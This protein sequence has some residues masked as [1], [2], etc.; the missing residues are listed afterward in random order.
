MAENM[1]CH[2]CDNSTEWICAQCGEPV[3]EDCCAV[4]SYMNLIEE[5]RCKECEDGI[6][7]NRADEWFREHRKEEATNAVKAARAKTRKEND[8]KPENVQKR[9]LAKIA[10]KKAEAEAAQKRMESAVKI[11]SE[12]FRGMF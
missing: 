7:S 8:W 1:I 4:S 9:R 6:Q 11:V 2:M 12:M 5:T 3:C 10:R